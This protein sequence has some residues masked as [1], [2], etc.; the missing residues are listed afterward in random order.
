[1]GDAL[2]RSLVLAALLT[3]LT[4]CAGEPV[5]TVGSST[6]ISTLDPF[7][8]FSRVEISLGDH[9]FQTLTFLDR[10]METVPS[11]ATSWERL[12]G[13][14]TWVFHL[15]EGVRFTNGEPFDGEAVKFSVDLFIERNRQGM[16]VGGASVALPSSEITRVVVI[17]PLTVS[18]DTARPKALLPF[19]MTQ[20][21]MLAPGH[22]GGAGDA[23]RAENPVGTGP[24]VLQERIRDSH[25][26]LARNPDYWGPAPALDKVVFRAIPEISTRVAEL[27]IGTIHIIGDLPFDQAGLLERSSDVHVATVSGGRRVMIGI[28]TQGG[29]EPLTDT[30]VRQA[31]NYA[32][33]FDAINEGLYGGAATRMAA[34]FNPPFRH[35]DLSPYA[36]DPAR[37]RQLLAEAGYPN[38]FEL[39]SLDTP[40]GKWIQ[41][42]ELAQTIA[43]QL[44]E[45]GVTLKEGVRTYEWGNYR[46][47]LL[48]HDLP[49]LFMQASGGEFELQTEAADLTIT[50]PSNFYNWENAA[51]EKLWSELLET[52]D[53][54]RRYQ[55]GLEMQ[56]LVLE[57]APWIFLYIQVDTYGVSDRISWSPRMD[58]VIHLW[59]VNWTETP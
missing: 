49:G 15:R 46:T 30:R 16:V 9:I 26:T 1:M 20:I 5:L 14:T 54:E 34:V 11:L 12:P 57:E 6:D 51:Y 21:Y 44:A 10:E 53:S 39:A 29:P 19:Y 17:D 40:I 56:E 47:K 37:A 55:I 45:V 4:A 41:D 43:S 27:E 58:E 36:Y 42:F 38:G 7:G 18:I 33:D 25:V 3:G 13:D 8:M 32:I 50:S 23:E 2:I 52:M 48:G 28:K 31:L 35:P 24:Y 22:Y 59:D